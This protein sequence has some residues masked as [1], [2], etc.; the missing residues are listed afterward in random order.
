LHT[1]ARRAR[2]LRP[3]VDVGQGKCVWAPVRDQLADVAKTRARRGFS[4]SETATFVFS[5]K[6]PLF[7]RLQGQLSGEALM[8]EV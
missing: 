4:A 2:R 5:L 8:S 3:P 7:A 6:E 1:R